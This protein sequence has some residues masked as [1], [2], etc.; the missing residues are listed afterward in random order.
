MLLYREYNENDISAM[1]SIW[2]SVFGDGESFVR[3][4]IHGLKDYG[5][6]VVAE[7]NGTLLGCAYVI[8]GQELVF[9]DVNEEHGKYSHA[10]EKR[11]LFPDQAH[12]YAHELHRIHALA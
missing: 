2:T 3:R 7:E 6:A 9:P 10:S 1:T 11:S 8:R 4:F 5:T 12:V